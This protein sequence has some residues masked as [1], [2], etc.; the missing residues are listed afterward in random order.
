MTPIEK[1]E[2]AL[3]SRIER[4][5]ANL[6]AASTEGE[7]QLQFQSLIVCVGIGEA[8]RDY[9]KTIG[10]FARGRHAELKQAHDSLTARH[11]RVLQSG[12]ELL[13]RFK[14]NPA[15]QALRKEIDLA[16][17][18][19]ANIQ[20]TL[21]HGADSLR[22]DVGP[23]MGM[24]DELALTVRRFAE[25]DQLE[26]MKRIT[27]SFLGHAHELYRTQPTL[28]SKDIIDA[29]AWENSAL[30]EV[31]QAADFHEAYARAGFQAIIA[32]EVMTM[33]VSSQP[34]EDAAEAAARANEA[35][36][37]RL[38]QIATRLAAP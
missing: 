25:A 7:Q 35:A 27:K 26:G 3:N 34:P 23:S 9:V 10:D 13:E 19:M 6:A 11:A 22:R 14:A 12:N 38:K 32:I 16:Q 20:K 24:I 8:L 36:A 28:P 21:R 5:Q 33:A 15:D 2:T 31:D 17:K 37:S 29:V 1:A 4:I 18:D 30:T